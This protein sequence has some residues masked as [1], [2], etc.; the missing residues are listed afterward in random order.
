MGLFHHTAGKDVISLAQAA[1]KYWSTLQNASTLINESAPAS[2]NV[3]MRKM[4]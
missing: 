2:N 4:D 3:M 1:V